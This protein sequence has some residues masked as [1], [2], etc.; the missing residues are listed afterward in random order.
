MDRGD[1]LAIP[2]GL[3]SQ[4]SAYFRRGLVMKKFSYAGFVCLLVLCLYTSAMSAVLPSG[5]LLTIDNGFE[6]ATSYFTMAVSSTTI[7]RGCAKIT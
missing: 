5:T 1:I 4:G 7:L 2:G 6:G 3:L